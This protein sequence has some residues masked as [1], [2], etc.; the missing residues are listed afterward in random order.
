M[1]SRELR[2]L[3]GGEP[4]YNRV[5]IVLSGKQPKILELGFLAD[6]IAFVSLGTVDPTKVYVA[7]NKP[8]IFIPVSEVIIARSPVPV[9]NRILLTW[10]A[11]EEGKQITIYYAG[12]PAV[13]IAQNLVTIGADYVG[14]AKETTLQAIRDRLPASLSPSG[15]MRVSVMDIVQPSSINAE[16]LVFDNAS[17]VGDLVTPLYG[18]NTPT[19]NA[20]VYYPDSN[21]IPSNTSI[22]WIGNNTK[23]KFIF[24]PG[25]K[26][27]T[28]I[29]DLSKIYVK[30]PAG[31][32]ATLYVLWEV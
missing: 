24:I 14:L 21:I 5:N 19:R 18:A 30:I 32:R 15:D 11:S 13:E 22:I 7:F 6:F 10:D 23:Q 12:A 16:E 28:E 8:M 4:R 9:F 1:T 17:G 26:I 25:S 3:G 31:A 27:T 2:G 20:V 29:D